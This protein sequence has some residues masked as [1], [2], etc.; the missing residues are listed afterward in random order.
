MEGIKPKTLPMNLQLLSFL[1]QLQM[2]KE[3]GAKK[4]NWGGKG[5]MRI[6]FFQG[7]K[8]KNPGTEGERVGSH[9]S[10]QT[11]LSFLR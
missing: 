10:S 8:R 3:P 7:G 6:Q 1:Y 4:T 9:L 2:S 11:R 5:N